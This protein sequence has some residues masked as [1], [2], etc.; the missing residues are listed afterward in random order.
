MG[1]DYESLYRE[2]LTREQRSLSELSFLKE[3]LLQKVALVER[4]E[5]LS[6]RSSA[7]S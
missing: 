2:S 4:Q 7:S 5:I 1:P 3:R 6:W